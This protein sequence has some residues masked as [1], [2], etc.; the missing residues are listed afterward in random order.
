MLLR[1]PRTVT[2]DPPDLWLGYA[3]SRTKLTRAA[4]AATFCNRYLVH[5]HTCNKSSKPKINDRHDKV[6]L[7]RVEL[8]KEAGYSGVLV[9]PTFASAATEARA[10]SSQFRGDVLLKDET[11]LSTIHY[12]TDDV[13]VH[14]LS[15]T[16]I[17]ITGSVS[18][19]RSHALGEAVKKMEMLYDNAL[20]M[21]RSAGACRTGLRKVNF[22][23]CA[24]N[25]LGGLSEHA[26][27]FSNGADGF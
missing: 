10:D 21:M 22:L 19:I 26:V 4:T 13:V 7:V 24:F 12:V 25:S 14:P 6:K 23:P 16:C 5:A 9:E 11:S 18:T 15:P 2:V 1:T 3:T 27:K 20:N 17:R 8:V